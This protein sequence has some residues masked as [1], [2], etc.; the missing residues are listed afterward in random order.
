M[1]LIFKT[2][3]IFHVVALILAVYFVFIDVCIYLIKLTTFC[4]EQFLSLTLTEFITT[5][6][7]NIEI[8]NSHLQYLFKV[9]FTD[10][11]NFSKAGDVSIN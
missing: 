5:Q 8:F 6:K 4:L 1:F 2:S 11:A 7:V 9:Y 3:I 10:I